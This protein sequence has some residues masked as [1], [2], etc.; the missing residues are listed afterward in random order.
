MAPRHRHS[1]WRWETRGSSLSA[2]TGTPTTPSTLSSTPSSPSLPVVTQGGRPL[3]GDV[4]AWHQGGRPLVG[5][6]PSL[7]APLAMGDAVV[8]RHRQLL[9]RGLWANPRRG[10]PTWS[11]LQSPCWLLRGGGGCVYI[12][13][14][15]GSGG[16]GSYSLVDTHVSLLRTPG[17]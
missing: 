4:F 14:V 16:T 13:I 7:R 12:F 6:V 5:A 1:S 9:V 17:G 2:S 8:R 10:S 11:T 3:V 15:R